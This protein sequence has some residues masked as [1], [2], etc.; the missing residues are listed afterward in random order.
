M[1]IEEIA[2][3]LELAGLSREQQIKLISSIKR[4]GFDAKAID[5]KLILMG[6]TPIFSI[7]DDDEADTQEKA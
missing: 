2:F 1:T 7:Y 6:F 4:G 5:K 3:E